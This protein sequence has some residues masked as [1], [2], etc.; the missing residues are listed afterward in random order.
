MII[1]NARPLSLLGE[2]SFRSVII[3]SHAND[4]GLGALDVWYGVKVIE[5]LTHLVDMTGHC[6]KGCL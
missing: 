5:A 4:G 2:R 1:S 3:V 6:L